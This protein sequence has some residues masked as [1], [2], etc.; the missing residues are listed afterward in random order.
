MP[1][2]LHEKAEGQILEAH[3]TG[4]LEKDDYQRF[5]PIVERMINQHG[6]IRVL[7]ELHDFH[8]W[9]AGALWE[10]IKF[11][12]KH[13]RDITR[14]AII[15]ETKWERG[16]ALFCRPFTTAKVKYFTH[17]QTA[18]AWDWIND[19]THAHIKEGVEPPVTPY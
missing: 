9:T 5:A 8:G 19:V 12:I 16:M 15:G 11:D 7:L 17:D 2:E 13:F 18:Q 10:D 3:A 1:I 6:K 14:L 4:K